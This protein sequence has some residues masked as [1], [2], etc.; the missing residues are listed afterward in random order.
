[1]GQIYRFDTI[2]STNRIA[3]ELAEEGAMHGTAVI[4][5]QQTGG[6]GRLGKRWES[7]SGKGL[8]CSII[9]RPDIL[10]ERYA[11]ITMVAGLAVAKVMDK[12]S[13]VK[14][15]LKWPNDVFLDD[16]K[17]GG[18]LCESSSLAAGYEAPYAVVGIGLNVNSSL[19]EFPLELRGTVTSLAIENG[20]SFEID[21]LFTQVREQLLMELMEFSENGFSNILKQWKERDLLY[22]RQMECVGF[23]G[24][25]IEGVALGPDSE[26]Q[27]HLRDS[28]G[29]EHA[30]L[31]G[32]VRL[33]RKEKRH[34]E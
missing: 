5:N 9:V 12:C 18:I 19:L 2:D 32:D 8:Y 3:K 7:V 31:S 14:C 4:T 21:S 33:A 6:R 15:K 16:R 22:G 13:S 29:R 26:G 30:V 17:C 10:I 1:M 27:L 28:D 34:S 20:K 11:Q 23:D 24:S 25:I